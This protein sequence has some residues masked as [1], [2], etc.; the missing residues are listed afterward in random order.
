MLLA[1]YQVRLFSKRISNSSNHQYQPQISNF[2]IYSFSLFLVRCFSSIIQ[3]EK[4]FTCNF[5]IGGSEVLST[6]GEKSCNYTYLM[7]KKHVMEY[8]Y[9]LLIGDPVTHREDIYKHLFSWHKQHVLF[10]ILRFGDC[11]KVLQTAC[12]NP[13]YFSISPMKLSLLDDKASLQDARSRLVAGQS[14]RGEVVVI[15]AHFPI[16]LL[17]KPNFKI[18]NYSIIIIYYD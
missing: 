7:Y 1:L 4:T 17:K 8:L 11:C 16:Y 12:S 13:S 14:T 18:E 5:D 15:F 10:D 6:T 9:S 2:Q 3:I